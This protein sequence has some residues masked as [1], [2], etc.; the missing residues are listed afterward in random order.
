[1]RYI[2]GLYD[3][4]KCL[5]ACTATTIW[6]K[7]HPKPDGTY[8]ACNFFNAYLLSIDGVPDGLYC[9]MYRRQWGET[10]ATNHGQNRG[11][12]YYSVSSSYGYT[13]S[14]LDLEHV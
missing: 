7:A 14:P 6:N 3:A 4:G 1:M 8:E 11:A 2:P 5:A 12:A 10:E 9:S 13:L